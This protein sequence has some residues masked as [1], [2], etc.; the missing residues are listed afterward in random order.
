MRFGD[1]ADDDAALLDGLGGV[2]D[3]E[4]AALRGAGADEPV[5]LFVRHA[6]R[7]EWAR[8]R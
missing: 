2:L 7:L 3:L 5:S 6:E 4:D 8:T 1:D